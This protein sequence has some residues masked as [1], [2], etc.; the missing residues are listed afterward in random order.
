[1]SDDKSSYCTLFECQIEKF[2]SVLFVDVM[3]NVMSN[4]IRGD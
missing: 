3:S 1:M 4:F 2:N